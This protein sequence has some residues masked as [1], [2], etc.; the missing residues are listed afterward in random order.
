MAFVGILR[1]EPVL[2]ALLISGEAAA[3]TNEPV[4]TDVEPLAEAFS[5]LVLA[6]R[7]LIDDA[8]SA[9]RR[10]TGL[11]AQLISGRSVRSAL[12]KFEGPLLTEVVTTMVHKLEEAGSRLRRHEAHA[13]HAEGLSMEA[14]GR[15]FGVSR[16]RVSAL[17]H[18]PPDDAKWSL[19]QRALRS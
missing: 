3:T 18:S 11:R 15:L 8:E 5:G 4:S 16:Q 6:M 17:L 14:I 19:P 2:S 10:A 9:I 12:E 13:L 7:E 1:L